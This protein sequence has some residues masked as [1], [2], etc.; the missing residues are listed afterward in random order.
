M[1]LMPGLKYPRPFG[2]SRVYHEAFGPNVRKRPLSFDKHGLHYIWAPGFGQ[3]VPAGYAKNQSS[4]RKSFPTSKKRRLNPP[5]T[6]RPPATSR[7]PTVVPPRPPNVPE[8]PTR[9]PTMPPLRRRRVRK[10]VYQTTGNYAGRFK[11]PKKASTSKFQT[12]GA[13][14]RTEKGGVA[15]WDK[16]V[17]V[18]HSTCAHS[19]V[20]RTAAHA[21]IRLV[22]KKAG[23]DFHSFKE[24]W[25][26]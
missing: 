8:R 3:Y 6:T 9:R 25:G 24:P 14:I 16:C 23:H 2:R 4:V 1:R 19:K 10:R 13:L 21:L 15:E 17:Y 26:S 22:F 11:G 12:L 20:L 7:Y 5:G 18:G